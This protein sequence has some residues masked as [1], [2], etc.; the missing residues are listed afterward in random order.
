MRA[1]DGVEHAAITVGNLPAAGDAG[2]HGV[3]H[4]HDAGAVENRGR[5]QLLAGVAEGEADQ[6]AERRRGGAAEHRAGAA[7][8]LADR[9]RRGI[10]IAHGGEA[11][12]EGLT[13]IAVTGQCVEGVE[14]APRPGRR[15]GDPGESLPERRD[16]EVTHCCTPGEPSSTGSRSVASSSSRWS[17][18][19]D[20]PAI[21][22]DAADSPTKTRRAVTFAS[23]SQ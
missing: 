14:L 20:A 8:L 16:V 9:R 7:Q 19:I 22:S 1:G 23:V 15:V 12:D 11:G 13:E 10:V 6:R 17:T 21:S 2:F 3:E 18:L 5:N 4:R